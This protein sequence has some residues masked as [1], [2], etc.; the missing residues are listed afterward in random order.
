MR[1]LSAVLAL[2]LLAGCVAGSEPPSARISPKTHEAVHSYQF[3]TCSAKI[4]AGEAGRIR[5]FLDPLGLTAQDTLVI[6]VPKNR[7]PRRDPERVKTLQRILAAYPARQRYI[8][9]S[10]LRVLPRSEPQGIIRVV[11]TAGVRVACRRDAPDLGCTSAS[12]LGAMIGYPA[13]TF[14][15]GYNPGGSTRQSRAATNFAPSA[16]GSAAGAAP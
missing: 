11:R 14:M 1:R 15:P 10:D 12:N 6:S 2:A 16:S 4:S 3:E 7:L 8:Q 13:D 5:A 9:D